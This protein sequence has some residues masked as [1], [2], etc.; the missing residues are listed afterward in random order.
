M[1]NP[2]EDNTMKVT[3]EKE[4]DHTDSPDGEAETG[5]DFI[6]VKLRNVIDME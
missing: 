5:T 1:K 2:L 3:P 6:D 4:T